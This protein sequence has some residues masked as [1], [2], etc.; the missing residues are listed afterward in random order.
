MK[1]LLMGLFLVTSL[2]AVADDRYDYVEDKLELKYGVLTDSKKNTLDIDDFEMGVFNGHPF[3]NMEIE[4]FSGD[5]GW[6]KFDKTS[7]DKI[8]KQIADDVRAMLNTNEPV[9]ITLIL[10]KEIGKDMM[11]HSANY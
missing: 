8:A 1:K 11:L 9:E 10:D 3:V 6:E 5:G 4:A 2:M 7:Y